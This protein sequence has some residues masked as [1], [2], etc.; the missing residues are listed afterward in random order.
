[1]TPEQRRGMAARIASHQ[2]HAPCTALHCTAQR[3]DVLHNAQLGI[4]P[5][6]PKISGLAFIF[7]GTFEHFV[8]ASMSSR[9]L[10]ISSSNPIIEVLS[11]VF[12][13]VFGGGSST[14]NSGGTHVHTCA[15]A[16]LLHA[17][18]SRGLAWD[19]H[20]STRR[21]PNRDRSVVR[22][23][24]VDGCLRR[25][26]TATTSQ[27]SEYGHR[28]SPRCTGPGASLEP[29]AIPRPSHVRSAI[30]GTS[31]AG[32][33]FGWRSVLGGVS[34]PRAHRVRTASGI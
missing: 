9:S 1:M 24:Y 17:L 27:R 12:F 14:K 16:V 23:P 19:T 21:I 22:R 32:R 4:I 28:S 7:R 6:F 3:G 29:R 31:E 15:H 8:C 10:F 30:R 13:E 20:E 5:Q 34:A 25:P 11:S 18:L 2:K 26:E 33:A